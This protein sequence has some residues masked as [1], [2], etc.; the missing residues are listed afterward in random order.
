MTHTKIF[1][2]E[3]FK[4]VIEKLEENKIKYFVFGGFALDFL[5]KEETDHE[6]LDIF[7][8]DS[9]K[10]LLKRI[11][12]DL[13]Y[14][15]KMV[16]RLISFNKPHGDIIYQ[17]E[18]IPIKKFKKYYKLRGNLSQDT[19]SKEA[20][21]KDNYIKFKDTLFRAMPFEWFSLYRKVNHRNPLKRER[22]SKAMNY[23]EKFAKKVKILET[24]D[25]K[26][27]KS[28]PKYVPSETK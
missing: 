15:N 3:E 26:R 24:K 10:D 1:D 9:H 17:I 5:N 20:F 13:G 23:A 28:D 18:A 21:E 16:G 25:I 6:D 7:I 12:N 11:L 19:I 4:K 22:H 27:L 2:Y 8:L 14:S